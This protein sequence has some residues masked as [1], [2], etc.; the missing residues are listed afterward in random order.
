MPR[1]GRP[2][3]RLVRAVPSSRAARSAARYGAEILAS[4]APQIGRA[5]LHAGRAQRQGGGDAARVADAAGGDHRHPHRV[6]DLRDQRE[7]ADLRRDVVGQEHAAMPAGLGA[8]RD[9]RVG[10]VRFEPARLR[11]RRGRAETSQPAALR[12]ASRRRAGRNGS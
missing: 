6:D 7:G 9:D 12:R 10:A 2:V 8:L 5:D 1:A 3:M 11:H 4:G